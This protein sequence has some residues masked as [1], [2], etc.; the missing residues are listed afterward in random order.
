MRLNIYKQETYEEKV[1]FP[2]QYSARQKK[3]MKLK[4]RW[5]KLKEQNSI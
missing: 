1:E 3:W 4:K 5:R 2:S